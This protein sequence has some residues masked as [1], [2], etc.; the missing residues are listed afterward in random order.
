MNT[1]AITDS[2]ASLGDLQGALRGLWADIAQEQG[3][4]LTLNDIAAYALP[5]TF[6]NGGNKQ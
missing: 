3:C 5:D 4:S 1:L 6:I 2:R